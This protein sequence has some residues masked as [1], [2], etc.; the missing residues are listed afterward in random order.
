MCPLL[1]CAATRWFTVTC[2]V[3]AR[4]TSPATMSSTTPPEITT[5]TGRSGPSGLTATAWQAMR[6]R[7]TQGS[8]MAISS[9]TR[10][11][12][13]TTVYIR[14]DKNRSGSALDSKNNQ[15]AICIL[16]H[17]VQVD[18][19]SLCT[20]KSSRLMTCLYVSR[21]VFASPILSNPGIF[22]CCQ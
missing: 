5:P 20:V 17:M 9:A 2:P 14:A 10:T 1:Q 4:T 13:A 7:S 15:N 21:G 19:S 3:R 16:A 6:W 12:R 8:S 11:P 22:Y 18:T